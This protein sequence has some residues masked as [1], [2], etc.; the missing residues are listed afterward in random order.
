M[1][2]HV[3]RATPSPPPKAELAG[4]RCDTSA[5]TCTCREP[6]QESEEAPPAEGKK[7]LEIRLS[8]HGGEATLD[9]D[10]GRL[11][12]SGAKDTC[13]YLDV[14]A[15]S[16]THWR[17]DGQ[18]SDPDTGFAPRLAIWEYG[19]EGPFWYEVLSFDCAGVG[20]KCDSAGVDK[21]TGTLAQRKRGR[22]DPCGSM[23]VTGLEW[24]TTGGLAHRDHGWYRDFFIT[25]DME[26]KKFMPKFAPHSTECVP[27]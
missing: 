15:G 25:F 27:K 13:Y 12:A 5:G 9:S 24:E 19:A 7:R 16:K 22:M 26:A 6:G 10:L 1:V 8:A 23:V 18:A 20:G 14:D 3:D 2:Q 11:T 17:F 21:W 4:A